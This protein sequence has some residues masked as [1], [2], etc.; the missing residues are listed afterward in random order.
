MDNGRD[1]V[2]LM[3]RARRAYE[4]GRARLAVMSAALVTFIVA[5]LTVLAGETSMLAWLPVTFVVWVALVVVGKEWLEG[6][7]FGVLAGAATLVLPMS[8][9]RP[10]CKPGMDMATMGADCCTRPELCIASG[11]GLGLLLALALPSG[12][13]SLPKRVV[14]AAA[15]VIAVASL[16]CSALFWGEALGLVAGIGAGLLV[17]SAA[18]GL[19]GL[20]L[21]R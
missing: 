10:C 1:D 5:I 6:G 20:R 12:P 15:G 14:G 21:A 11:A 16:R 9:L 18:R 2:E 8:I 17:A 3:V 4:W 7:R 13:G 19:V